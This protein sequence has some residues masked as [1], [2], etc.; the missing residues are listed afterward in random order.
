MGIIKVLGLV[1][2]A[3]GILEIFPQVP[4]WIGRVFPTYY[5][6]NPLLEISRN[7]A[8]FADV[9][10]DLAILIGFIVI[11]AFVLAREI[12]RQQQQLALEG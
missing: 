9:A 12:Q 1:L 2:Y 5:I 10:L 4:Q 7:A 8:R 11:L 6:M 3:P